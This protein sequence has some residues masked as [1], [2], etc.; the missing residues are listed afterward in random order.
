MPNPAGKQQKSSPKTAV[1]L[2]RCEFE[3]LKGRVG[4]G[5]AV[6]GG[7]VASFKKAVALVTELAV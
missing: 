7:V 2:E 1:C 4:G 3:R 6:E 5:V